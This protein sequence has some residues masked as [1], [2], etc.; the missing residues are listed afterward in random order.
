MIGLSQ[1]LKLQME[2]QGVPIM[3]LLDYQCMDSFKVA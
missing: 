3:T 1:L 2:S